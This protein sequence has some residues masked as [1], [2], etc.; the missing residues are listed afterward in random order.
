VLDGK[1]YRLETRKGDG[2]LRSSVTRDLHFPVRAI[3]DP[4]E[5]RNALQRALS[6]G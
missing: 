3:F 4:A 1:S 5:N 2:E 6:A